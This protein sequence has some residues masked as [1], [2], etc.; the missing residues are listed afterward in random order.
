MKICDL[1]TLFTEG[2]ES[3]M[4]TY[5]REKARYCSAHPEHEHVV[6]VP[7]R[8]T[9]R[10]SWF[11]NRVHRIKSRRLPWNV[12]HRLLFDHGAVRSIL[13]QERPD[14]VEVDCAY[15]LG[16]V[17]RSA[18][19]AVPIVGFYHVHLPTFIA[20]PGTSRFG[21]PIGWTVEQLAWA[22]TRFCQRPCDRLIVSSRDVHDRLA[23]KGFARLEH[24]PLGVNLGLFRPLPAA[25]D[26]PDRPDRNGAA[27]PTTILYVGRLSHEKDLDVLLGAFERLEGGRYRLEIVGDG[28]LRGALEQRARGRPNVTFRGFLPYGDELA[29]IYARADLFVNPSP[30]ETFSLSI[31]EALASGL[32]VVAARRGGP[33]DLVDATVGALAEPGDPRDFARCIEGLAHHRPDAALCRRHVVERFSWDRTFDRL[34]AVYAAEIERRAPARPTPERAYEVPRA[35]RPAPPRAE[36][37]ERSGHHGHEEHGGH[38]ERPAERS[39][40]G[41]AKTA[42]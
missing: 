42:G 8:E 12:D 10:E 7:A 39:T 30:N 36:R 41:R 17:A 11:G 5:L 20:R 34:V 31:L 28:P 13:R 23:A 18:L 1:T 35:E 32:P 9:G 40:A 19:P 25:P 6:I 26:G 4:N 38:Q 14:V 33:I 37:P 2:A 21:A 22:Y 27:A 29:R 3:G 24:T 16:R 15:F